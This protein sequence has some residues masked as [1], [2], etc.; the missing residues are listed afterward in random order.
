MKRLLNPI[1]FLM[2]NMPEVDKSMDLIMS[3]LQATTESVK[4]IKNG[5][6]SFHANVLKM[7]PT[8]TKPKPSQAPPAQEPSPEPA[9]AGEEPVIQLPPAEQPGN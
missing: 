9:E 6:E 7:A 1:L 5:I 8:V 3:F 2:A 4:N